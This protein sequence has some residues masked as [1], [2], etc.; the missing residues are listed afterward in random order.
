MGAAAALAAGDPEPCRDLLGAGPGLTPAGDDVVAGAMAACALLG[1]RAA[2]LELD[3]LIAR[4][5]LA[6]T[7]LSAALLSCAARGEVVPEAAELLRVLGSGAAVAPALT[8]LRAVG[9][10]SGTALAIGM[11][12][13]LAAATARHDPEL[14]PRS[15]H[16]GS[17]GA[18]ERP[19]SWA[20]AP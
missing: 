2:L 12:A 19:Q 15:S 20:V 16:P 7:A 1:C 8:R 9:S 4:A 10:T 14:D 3:M 11:V 13:A 6:T 18:T 5:R 17:V